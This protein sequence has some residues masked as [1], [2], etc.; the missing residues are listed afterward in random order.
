MNKKAFYKTLS[1]IFAVL[2]IVIAAVNRIYEFYG[3]NF[4]LNPHVIAFFYF[5]YYIVLDYVTKDNQEFDKAKRVLLLA[6]FLFYLSE[7][8]L[9]VLT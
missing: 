9:L 6:F 2:F 7:F 1:Y 4:L 8:I 3:K 5:T